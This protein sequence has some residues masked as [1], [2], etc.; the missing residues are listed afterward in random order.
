MISSPVL[1]KRHKRALKPIDAAGNRCFATIAS[2]GHALIDHPRV[3][4]GV[5]GI[6]GHDL[7]RWCL[8]VWWGFVARAQL[9]IP[10]LWPR[11][12]F[13]QGAVLRPPGLYFF[14]EVGKT[15]A[16]DDIR[17]DTVRSEGAEVGTPNI[18]PLTPSASPP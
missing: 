16:G 13:G 15:L 10:E 2:L 4:V 14:A 5:V 1:C 18:A 3:A 11:I 17:V 6:N 12:L 7:E 8:K 9:P